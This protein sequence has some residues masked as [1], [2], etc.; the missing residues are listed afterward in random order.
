MIKIE[1][2]NYSY[3]GSRRVFESLD[4]AIPEGG[5]CGLLGK[6]GVGKTTFFSLV[7]GLL[8]PDKNSKI[9]V[10]GI[11]PKK[12]EVKFLQRIFLLP[13]EFELPRI[14]VKEFAKLYGQFYPRYS[15]ELFVRLLSDFEVTASD[16]FHQM[17]FGQRKKAFISF[18][19][20]CNTELLL[21]DEPTNGLDIPSKTAFRRALASIADD[22]RT[23]IISTHQVRDLEE[24]LDRVVVME[25]NK[26]LL[27]AS[28]E[29]ITKKLR[30]EVVEPTQNTL[31]CQPTIHGLLGVTPN[32]EG[33]SETK[34]DMELLFNA[35]NSS[36]EEI[37]RIF[38]A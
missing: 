13:E 1:N 33:G 35:V 20:A 32:Y 15:E 31:Y 19:I 30:F 5:I 9:T 24:I 8:H 21:L 6:N 3:R 25:S 17:S 27:N 14:S 23:I 36:P 34:L 26:V 18:A 38:N 37:N 29:E 4:I 28:T 2:L 7:S 12:H 16:K 22:G 10:F 11:E